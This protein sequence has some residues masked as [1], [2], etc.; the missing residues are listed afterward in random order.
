MGHDFVEY[1][2]RSAIFRDPHLNLVRC[3]MLCVAEQR[4][5]AEPFTS[6]LVDHLRDFYWI[7]NGVFSDFHIDQLLREPDD[8]RQF[9]AF[10]D[11]CATFLCDKGETLNQ[12][13]LN[14]IVGDSDK[15]DVDLSVEY[16][17]LGLGRLAN[18]V[19]GVR[20]AV[21]PG[22]KTAW[23]Y[24]DLTRRMKQQRIIE[25]RAKG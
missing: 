22:D 15:W 19:T 3:T 12:S 7:G 8:V 9:L 11:D 16:P 24:D 1:A 18:L 5:Y 2:G 14:E 4:D 25:H 23:S 17:L 10:L 20:A 21:M 13:T 6:R